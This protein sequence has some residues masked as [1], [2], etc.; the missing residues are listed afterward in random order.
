MI[1]ILVVYNAERSA[2]MPDVRSMVELGTNEQ[3]RQILMLYA[4]GGEIGKSLI[5]PPATPPQRLAELRAAFD[6]MIKDSAL[7]AEI[8]TAKADFGPLS[9]KPLQEI[10]GR[11]AGGPAN[12]A[13]RR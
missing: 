7:L 1:N 10:V 5:A 12:V 8:E 11:I 9:A 4:S 3:D 2:E 13:N 6:A